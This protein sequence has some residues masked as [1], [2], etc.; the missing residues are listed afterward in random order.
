M[1][2]YL[3]MDYSKDFILIIS[4]VHKSLIETLERNKYNFEYLPDISLNKL[5]KKN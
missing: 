5:K 3:S 4:Q 1:S 2:R